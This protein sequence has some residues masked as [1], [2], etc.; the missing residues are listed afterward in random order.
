MGK[1]IFAFARA[2]ALPGYQAAKTMTN[3]LTYDYDA[4]LITEIS[5]NNDVND[6]DVISA[7]IAAVSDYNID[8]TYY[9]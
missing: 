3:I 6:A 1:S 9:I 2:A 8:I 4:E 5:E 7:L